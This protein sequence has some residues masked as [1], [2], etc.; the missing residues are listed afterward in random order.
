MKRW[1]SF[2]IVLSAGIGQQASASAD[3][4]F[5][6]RAGEWETSVTLHGV[7]TGAPIVNR[8]CYKTDQTIDSA[9]LASMTARRGPCDPPSVSSTGNVT[10]YSL[11]CSTPSGKV[12]TQGEVT[13]TGA[14]SYT[15]HMVSHF[16]GSSA[17]R[18][19]EI[20]AVSHRAGDC[21]PGD[22]ASPMHPG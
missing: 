4:G 20:T 3:P 9:M 13:R 17:L 7:G 11:S 16:E 22:K 18:V 12:A 15:N 10:T 19:M 8:I 5:V 2:V 14:D 21:Q 1:H 6:I